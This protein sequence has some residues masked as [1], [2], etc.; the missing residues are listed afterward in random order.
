VTLNDWW[1]VCCGK[2]NAASGVFLVNSFGV[3]SP[4]ALVRTALRIFP[5]AKP[6]CSFLLPSP[7]GTRDVPR[8]RHL[9]AARGVP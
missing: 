5:P 7:L 4:R 6:R 1:A 9:F 2:E 3:H 8:A